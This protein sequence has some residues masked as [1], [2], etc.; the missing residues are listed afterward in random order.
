MV[1]YDTF[2]YGHLN[3][4]S[5]HNVHRQETNLHCLHKIILM[6]KCHNL[7]FALRCMLA[8]AFEY[9]KLSEFSTQLF[10]II[11]IIVNLIHYL[12]SYAYVTEHHAFASRDTFPFQL[13]LTRA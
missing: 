3:E 4:G 8:M 13:E 2:E 7:H 5:I 1:I 12:H 6:T 10:I 11:I 9:V